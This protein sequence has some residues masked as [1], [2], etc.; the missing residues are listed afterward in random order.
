MALKDF[1]LKIGV[2]I[3]DLADKITQ[4]KVERQSRISSKIN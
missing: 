3:L 2:V 1:Q 4:K